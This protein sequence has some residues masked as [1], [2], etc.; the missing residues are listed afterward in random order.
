MQ[1]AWRRVVDVPPQ[2]GFLQLLL[3]ELNAAGLAFSLGVVPEVQHEAAE[4]C[5]G[6]LGV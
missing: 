3:Q 2:R 1:A 4:S 5:E 6:V